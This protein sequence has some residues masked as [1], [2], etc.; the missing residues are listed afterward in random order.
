M[1]VSSRTVMQDFDYFLPVLFALSNVTLPVSKLHLYPYSCPFL[2]SESSELGPRRV[3]AEGL[4]RFCIND[5]SHNAASLR[6]FCRCSTGLSKWWEC[7]GSAVILTEITPGNVLNNRAHR[8]Y[9]CLCPRT[10]SIWAVDVIHLVPP[11]FFFFGP[12]SYC[13]EKF[14][15]TYLSLWGK[16]NTEYCILSNSF[17]VPEGN[18][19]MSP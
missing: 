8:F 14:S 7:F 4:Y 18:G 10:V 16:K 1:W 19:N 9:P 11:A 13:R 12:G 6:L 17:S 2:H 5:S 3:E 15:D